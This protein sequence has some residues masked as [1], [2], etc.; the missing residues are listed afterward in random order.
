V[1]PD[2]PAPTAPAAPSPAGPASVPGLVSVLMPV[3]NEE[4]LLPECVARVCAAP[5][6]AGLAREIVLVEDCSTDGTRA[7]VDRLVAEHAGVIRAFHQPHNQGKGAAIRRA[8]EEMRGTYAIIQ[9]A[10]L[11]YDP[12]EYAMLLEPMLHRGADVVY[13]SRFAARTVRR[14]LNYHHEL[15]NKFLTACSNWFTGLNLTDMETCYKAFRARLLRS[16]PLRSNRFGI[17]PELTAKIARRRCI[18]YEVPISYHGRGY[19]EGK[20]IGWRDGINALYTILKYRIVD[21]SKRS[22]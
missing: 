15:G 10:D 6:P 4:R 8:I 22:E 16:I 11:E 20:K 2:R 13:G 1:T 18:V 19:H 21:D 7:V 17:E 12:S 9:D 14:V 5:L 3:Y